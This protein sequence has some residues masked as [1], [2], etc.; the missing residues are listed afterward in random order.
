MKC[1]NLRIRGRISTPEQNESEQNKR[2]KTL[3]AFLLN[4]LLFLYLS[5]HDRKKSC[6]D[7]NFQFDSEL[8]IPSTNEILDMTIV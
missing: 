2:R 5:V 8:E 7:F 1:R 4:I 6:N 3:L